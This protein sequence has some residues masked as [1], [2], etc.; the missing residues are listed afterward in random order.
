M[1]KYVDLIKR[2]RHEREEALRQVDRMATGRLEVLY[3][4]EGKDVVNVTA[5]QIA[6]WKETAD[7]LSK[8]IE[9]LEEDDAQRA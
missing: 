6:S 4:P 3:R 9:I 8:A 1:S 7:A 5:E 2:M